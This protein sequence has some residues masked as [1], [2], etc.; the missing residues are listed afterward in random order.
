VRDPKEVAR[1]RKKKTRHVSFSGLERSK[2]GENI[3]DLVNGPDVLDVSLMYEPVRL[4]DAQRHLAQSGLM[5]QRPPTQVGFA[6][7]RAKQGLSLDGGVPA[8]FVGGEQRGQVVVVVGGDR[9]S[10]FATFLLENGGRLP[11]PCCFLDRAQNH[12]ATEERD[13]REEK[14]DIVS[15]M[16]P[17]EG[18][19]RQKAR[20][21]RAP[22]VILLHA[23]ALIGID[24]SLDDERRSRHAS[25]VLP[26]H[27][28]RA[29]RSCTSAAKE[30]VGRL[31]GLLRRVVEPVLVGRT[32]VFFLSATV[33]RIGFVLGGVFVGSRLLDRDVVPTDDEVVANLGERGRPEADKLLLRNVLC[34]GTVRGWVNRDRVK[35]AGRLRVVGRKARQGILILLVCAL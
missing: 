1:C 19:V 22:R 24:P 16:S 10:Q 2:V 30:L 26:A 28:A 12:A 4:P 15:T 31:W 13:D 35:N 17:R 25:F 3:P 18:V 11:R 20:Q 6:S 32:P 8:I 27:L 21:A 23:L 7:M 34:T 5:R 33:S 29:R 9:L 14:K